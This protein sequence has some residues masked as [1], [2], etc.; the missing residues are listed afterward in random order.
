MISRDFALF[1]ITGGR[2]LLLTVRLVISCCFRLSRSILG[3]GLLPLLYLL[4]FPFLSDLLLFDEFL[5]GLLCVPLF[6]LPYALEI[7][8]YLVM[9]L[10][11]LSSLDDLPHDIERR[12]LVLILLIQIGPTAARLLATLFIGW[13]LLLLLL[14]IHKDLHGC[15]ISIL[16]GE[17]ERGI[18]SVGFVAHVGACFDE[19]THR[20][21]VLLLG[22]TEERSDAI[23]VD[24]IHIGTLPDQVYEHISIFTGCL[25]SMK[26]CCF[27]RA[28]LVVDSGIL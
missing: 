8:V 24:K 10:V 28:V 4:P 6:I 27:L 16:A 15:Q 5:F 25:K 11:T 3:C 17:M 19:D 21:V 14:S 1:C 13:L 26:D 2:A 18:M 22:S 20:L 9:P 23:Q 12:L 7:C